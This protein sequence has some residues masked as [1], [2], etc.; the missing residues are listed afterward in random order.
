VGLERLRPAILAEKP[1]RS[2]DSEQL[3]E[4]SP[5]AVRVVKAL[6]IETRKGETIEADGHRVGR[7][8]KPRRFGLE[9]ANLVVGTARLYGI[10]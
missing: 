1:S 9:L 3:V 5:Q 7:R 8:G 6:S 10:V 2:P 4:Y